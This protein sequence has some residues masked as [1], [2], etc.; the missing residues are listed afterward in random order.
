MAKALNSTDK[1]IKEAFSAV[2]EHN[3][4]IMERGKSLKD[5]MEALKHTGMTED[6]HNLFSDYSLV[7]EDMDLCSKAP[8]GAIFAL[9]SLILRPG[10][11]ENHAPTVCFLMNPLGINCVQKL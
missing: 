8:G 11:F 3:Y 2:L 4:L 5:G 7:G 9:K 6:Y 1:S 10:F